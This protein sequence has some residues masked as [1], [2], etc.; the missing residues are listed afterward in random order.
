M[1][2]IF[3]ILSL[4]LFA[5]VSNAQK[6][7]SFKC[8][9]YSFTLYNAEN[10]PIDFTFMAGDQI[11]YDQW[12]RVTRI[13][14]ISISYD[15]WDRVTRI[16]NVSVSYDQWDRCTRIGGMRLNYDQWDRLTGSSG[17]VGCNW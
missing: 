16:G 15:Q 8:G 9:G 13:G 7:V 6:G 5:Y 4:L 14:D 3:C 10:T 11:R 2:K 17:S 12:D 1:K